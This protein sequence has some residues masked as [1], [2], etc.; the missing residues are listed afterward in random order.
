[1]QQPTKADGSEKLESNESVP[2]NTQKEEFAAQEEKKD[3]IPLDATLVKP[4]LS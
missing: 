2:S 4:L 3:S 1:V